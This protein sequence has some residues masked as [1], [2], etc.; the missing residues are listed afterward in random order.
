[1][2]MKITLNRT[3]KQRMLPMDYHYYIS[4][5][6]YKVLNQSDEAYAAFLHEKG[7]GTNPKRLYKLFCFDRLNFGKPILWQEKKLFEISAQDI[8]LRVSFDVEETAVNFIKGLFAG[9][10][11]LIGDRFNS[12]DFKVVGIDI[13][14]MPQFAE[15]ERYRAFTPWVVSIKQEGKK[16]A[17]YL[18]PEATEF[19]PQAIKHLVDKFNY[20]QKEEY[21]ITANDIKLEIVG[22][23]K[24]SS[25]VIKSGTRKESKIF[26]NLMNFELTAP[27]EVHE[28]IWRTGICEKSSSGFGWVD[29]C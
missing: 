23:F 15:T 1:M 8:S 12:I 17:Q 26:G 6:I 28:M 25:Y 18:T 16:Y 4:A 22:D 5:W 11:F 20:T 7:Y 19:I 27:K 10:E 9:Q 14:P 3:T 29:R 2:R 13:L 24:R 21:N